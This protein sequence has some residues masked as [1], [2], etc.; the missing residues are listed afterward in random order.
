MQERLG[1]LKEAVAV[2][3]DKQIACQLLGWVG[4]ILAVHT[5]RSTLQERTRLDSYDA[6]LKAGW[7]WLAGASMTESQ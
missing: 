3:L 5:V 6:V 1:Q 2:G 4:S 7:E